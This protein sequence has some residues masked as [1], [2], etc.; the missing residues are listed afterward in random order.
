MSI[1]KKFNK[2]FILNL[3]SSIENKVKKIINNNTINNKLYN[4]LENHELNQTRINKQILHQK[5]N[6]DN[7]KKSAISLGVDDKKIN[8][9]ESMLFLENKFN[10]K[11]QISNIEN[12]NEKTKTKTLFSKKNNLHL[13]QEQEKLDKILEQLNNLTKIV[14]NI[15][16]SS[17]KEE[18]LLSKSKC[19][20]C[21]CCDKFNKLKEREKILS[22]IIEKYI[23]DINWYYY[24]NPCN[25]NKRDNW[26]Y[27]Y[28]N[29]ITFIRKNKRLPKYTKIYPH[30]SS[31]KKSFDFSGLEKNIYNWY[32]FQIKYINNLNDYKK[33]LI[34]KI[35]KLEKLLD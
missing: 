23:T 29:L 14:N 17:S 27:Y 32:K 15:Y 20:D 31:S 1:L 35:I 19:K 24:Y 5:Y 11:Q 2:K 13:S 3:N 7:D 26:Y 30:Q 25:I 33:K 6:I 4:Y 22:N 8:F 16:S 18:I 12:L 9:K 10:N 21:I 34:K 28:N